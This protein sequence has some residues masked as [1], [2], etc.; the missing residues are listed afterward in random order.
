MLNGPSIIQSVLKEN[1]RAFWFRKSKDQPVE[2]AVGNC[3]QPLPPRM[4]LVCK[5]CP[6][7]CL[8]F[9]KQKKK[10]KRQLFGPKK[11][12]EKPSNCKK[13]EK[14]VEK[15]LIWWETILGPSPKR[16]WPD[17]CTCRLAHRER[18]KMRARDPRLRDSRYQQTA[19][20]VLLYTE[21]IRRCSV[22]SCF[23]PQPKSPPG[24][25]IPKAAVF[26]IM[27]DVSYMVSNNFV[28]FLEVGF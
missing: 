17:P 7:K 6:S 8:E 20:D 23:E 27:E 18:K 22:S 11:Q 4:D 9:E 25:K 2:P 21:P 10:S 16:L 5:G 28:S 24:Y 26:K 13:E 15:K 12:S 14:P 19:G 3:A 1:I